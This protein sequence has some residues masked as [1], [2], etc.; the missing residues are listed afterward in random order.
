M[1]FLKGILNATFTLTVKLPEPVL[2]FGFTLSVSSQSEEQ[3]KRFSENLQTRSI[4][5]R[6]TKDEDRSSPCMELEVN[7]C[8]IKQIK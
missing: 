1:M 5:R 6:T 3:R 8:G 4:Y 7:L 2:P